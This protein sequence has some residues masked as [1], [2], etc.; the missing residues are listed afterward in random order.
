MA[1]NITGFGL[2]LV[3]VAAS[4]FPVGFTITQFADDTDP[5]DFPSLEIGDTAMGLNGDLIGWQV[6]NPIEVDLSV[7]PGSEDDLNLSILY[8]ANRISLG[9]SALFDAIT[10]TGTYSDGTIVILN[11]GFMVAGI[12]AKS[13]AS[14]GR[15]KSK[16]YKFKFENQVST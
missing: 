7:I 3:L 10:L 6:A 1:N 14:A 8:Q 15:L 16:T 12:P 4:T 2:K 5:L 9:K 11:N 13:V